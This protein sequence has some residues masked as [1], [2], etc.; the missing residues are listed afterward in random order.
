MR[1]FRAS[2]TCITGKA[3]LAD[4]PS[5]FTDP[6]MRRVTIAFGEVF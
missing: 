6:G 5:R 1:I 3:I 2:E 4:Q